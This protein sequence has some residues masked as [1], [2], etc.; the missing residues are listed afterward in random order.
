[1][2]IEDGELD[3]SNLVMPI[4]EQWVMV[5]LKIDQLKGKDIEEALYIEQLFRV[6]DNQERLIVEILRPKIIKFIK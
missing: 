3:L 6:L 2:M 1:M 4:V 5:R